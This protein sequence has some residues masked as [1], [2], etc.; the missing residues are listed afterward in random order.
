MGVMGKALW[1]HYG[2]IIYKK[3]V[4]FSTKYDQAAYFKNN[5]R[6]KQL[7]NF[8]WTNR[9]VETKLYMLPIGPIRIV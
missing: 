4:K 5:Q 7:N 8:I 3:M 2:P 6:T 9:K 1:A